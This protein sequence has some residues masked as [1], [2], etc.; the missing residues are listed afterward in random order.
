MLSEQ[1]KESVIA[2]LEPGSFFGEGCLAEQLARMF[3][4]TAVGNSILVRIDKQA[5]IRVL[6]EEPSF[7]EL[8]LTYL[9]S[10]DSLTRAR[11]DAYIFLGHDVFPAMPTYVQFCSIAYTPYTVEAP[12]NQQPVCT[13]DQ[14]IYY[15]GVTVANAPP[16]RL[17]SAAQ[18]Q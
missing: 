10:R 18:R 9:P 15:A 8:F 7:S 1:G 11:S 13:I 12:P 5:M 6:H 3:T 2:M 17:K 4:A 14:F 16:Y